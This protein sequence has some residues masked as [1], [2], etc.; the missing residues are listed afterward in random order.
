[1]GASSPMVC[2]N[3]AAQSSPEDVRAVCFGGCTRTQTH[4]HTQTDVLTRQLPQV[5]E[6]IV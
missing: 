6:L 4:T 1:M 5:I 2:E 3:I